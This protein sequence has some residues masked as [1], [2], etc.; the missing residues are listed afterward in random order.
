MSLNDPL[1]AVL[2]VIQNAE[3]RAKREITTKSNSTLIRTVLDIM[4]AQGY[5]GGYEVIPDSKGD[6][7]KI[8]IDGKINKVGVI[9]PRF[10]IKKGSFERFEKRYLPARGFGILIISTNQGLMTH[11]EAKEKGIGG[12]L[13]SYCY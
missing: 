10:Q 6:L 9:K 12:T 4:T 7:L 3:L 2:S 13:V 8:K 5:L 1:A 11:E